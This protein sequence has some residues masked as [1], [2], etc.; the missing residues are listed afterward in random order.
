MK[1]GRALAAEVSSVAIH[2]RLQKDLL[3][4]VQSQVVSV[5]AEH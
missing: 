1:T 2:T 3:P 5:A 4:V